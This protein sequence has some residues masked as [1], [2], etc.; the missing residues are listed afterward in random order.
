MNSGSVVATNVIA[1]SV[2]ESLKSGLVLKGT[3][4]SYAS[5]GSIGTAWIAIELAG[6]GS[7]QVAVH[8]QHN[9]QLGQEVEIQCVPN[10]LNPG[11]YMFRIVEATAST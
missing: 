7:R 9:L 5:D 10:P 3:V 6:I 8:S 2:M 4:A 11:H 1:G